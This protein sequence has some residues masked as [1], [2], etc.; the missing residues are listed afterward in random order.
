LQTVE[1]RF[2]SKV[3]KSPGLG[4]RGDCWLWRGGRRNNTLRGFSTTYYGGFRFRGK[5]WEAHRVSFLL[6]HDEAALTDWVLHKCDNPVDV[7][8]LSTCMSAML[9]T[10]RK[11]VGAEV[12]VTSALAAQST[13]ERVGQ[14]IA[15]LILLKQR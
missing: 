11:I 4:P 14:D 6:T 8:G 5:V 10:T 1:E 15:R 12:A 3:D 2:W 9:S 7:F 13:N